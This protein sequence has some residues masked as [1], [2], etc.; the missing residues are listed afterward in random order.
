M[1]HAMK[2]TPISF[3]QIVEG[4]KTL[5]VRVYDEKRRNFNV[6]DTVIFSKLPDKTETI[7]KTIIGI[8]IFKDFK[9]MFE[10]VDGVKA[11]WTIVDTP[12]KMEKDLTIYYTKEEVD[13]YG[14][15]GIFI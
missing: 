14:V 8:T 11:G 3:E 2:L 15:I 1:Q 6:G 9:T 7:E 5:E 4:S 10:N 12:E 13:K